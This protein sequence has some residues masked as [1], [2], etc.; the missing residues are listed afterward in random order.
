MPRQTRLIRAVVG[1]LNRD[2]K[3]L[4]AERPPN[5][6]YSG[7]W[8]FPGG[9]IEPNESGSDAL[10]REL[11]EELGIDVIASKRWFEHEHAYPDKI[12]HLEIWLVTH[13]TGEP[14]GK[15]NQQLRWATFNDMAELRLL[16]GNLQF[17]DKIKTLFS[18]LG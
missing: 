6:P 9:K 4:V 2:G 17:M 18:L 16:E 11:H 14:H 10:K 15:E 7:Y 12:V 13:F 8:E 1:I 3:V 5:K